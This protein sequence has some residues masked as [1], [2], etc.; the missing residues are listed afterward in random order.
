MTIIQIKIC[1]FS[2][3]TSANKVKKMTNCIF[4]IFS[5]CGHASSGYI[6]KIVDTSIQILKRMSQPIVGDQKNLSFF[7]DAKKEISVTKPII[8]AKGK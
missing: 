2:R 3:S 7:E 5:H 6:A 8:C 1:I 4:M